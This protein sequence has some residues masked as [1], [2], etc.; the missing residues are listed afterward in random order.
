MDLKICHVLISLEGN[1]ATLYNCNHHATRSK[2][3]K[4]EVRIF[5]SNKQKIAKNML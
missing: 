4:Y 5:F 3:L 1:S 2:S